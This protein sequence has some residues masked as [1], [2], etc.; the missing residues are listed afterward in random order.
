MCLCESLLQPRQS[1]FLT[2]HSQQL[3][4]LAFQWL[5]NSQCKVSQAKFYNETECCLSRLFSVDLFL[6]C[7]C[8][9]VCVCIETLG[10]HSK[11]QILYEAPKRQG[12]GKWWMIY[13]LFSDALQNYANHRW[14]VQTNLSPQS[15]SSIKSCSL[16]S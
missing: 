5:Y 3:R 10:S 11:L 15:L 6:I 13:L 16:N 7:V 12:K 8:V 14:N 4:W 9:F 2:V 1:V